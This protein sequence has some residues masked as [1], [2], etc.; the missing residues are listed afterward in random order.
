LLHTKRALTVATDNGLGAKIY[1]PDGSAIRAFSICLSQSQINLL[2]AAVKQTIIFEAGLLALIVS[3]VLWRN[4]VNCAP[5]P[6][7]PA[8]GRSL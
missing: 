5:L 3:F 8:A 7:Q 1:G 2:G 6:F 4:I